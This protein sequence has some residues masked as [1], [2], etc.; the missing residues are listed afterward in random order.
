MANKCV[1]NW[2][3]VDLIRRI[4]ILLEYKTLNTVV[5]VWG[6]KNCLKKYFSQKTF[7]LAIKGSL[8]AQGFA[9]IYGHFVYFE[10]YYFIHKALN[11]STF[12]LPGSE[13]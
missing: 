13:I 3:E 7:K 11:C 2:I 1:V 6:I 12:S 10:S 8:N 4:M 9:V 5:S